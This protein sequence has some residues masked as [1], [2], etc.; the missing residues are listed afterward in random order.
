MSTITIKDAG[1]RVIGY[2]ETQS[3]GTQS[4]KTVG[5]QIVVGMTLNLMS[6][7]TLDIV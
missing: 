5:Y 1:Y 6:P 2:I 3:D 4:A 7:W